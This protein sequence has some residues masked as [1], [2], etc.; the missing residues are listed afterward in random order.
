LEYHLTTAISATCDAQART[1]TTTMTMHNGIPDSITSDYTLGARNGRFGLPRTT[2]MLDVIFFAPPGAQITGTDPAASMVE[3]WERS[4]VEK[5]N[6]ALSKTVFVAQNET[7]TASYTV[8]FPEGAL[9]PLN[10]RHTPAV[11]PTQMAIDPGCEALFAL[12][13][14]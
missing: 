4:G 10:L 3:E 7:V 11:N 8:A 12:P 6:T 5:G 13:T 1:M 2:M 14:P 9:G